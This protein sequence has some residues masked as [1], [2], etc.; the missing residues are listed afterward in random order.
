M[1]VFATPPKKI[2]L[3]DT[4]VVPGNIC[5]LKT[6][7]V[8]K[9]SDTTVWVGLP[10]ANMQRPKVTLAGPCSLMSDSKRS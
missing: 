3:Q 8:L 9:N 7:E 2:P 6:Q 4:A 1:R 10:G 5:Y